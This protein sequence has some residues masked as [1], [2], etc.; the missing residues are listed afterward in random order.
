MTGTRL[1]LMRCVVKCVSAIRITGP[2]ET[3]EKLPD[4][5][6][7]I[8]EAFLKLSLS[9]WHGLCNSLSP[10]IVSAL[11]LLI[12]LGRSSGDPVK[13]SPERLTEDLV[14]ES[15]AFLGE[16]EGI[17]LEKGRHGRM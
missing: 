14:S 1:C 5:D 12:A 2:P 15:Q 6:R 13:A 16:A 10:M 9:A 8:P 17:R 3:A 7:K 4:P 11:A